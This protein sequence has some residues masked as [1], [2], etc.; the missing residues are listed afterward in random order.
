MPMSNGYNIN[1]IGGPAA[2]D[3]AFL[4]EAKEEAKTPR[5]A[6]KKKARFIVAC[7]VLAVIIGFFLLMY[8]LSRR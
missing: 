6:W 8:V 7:V 4:A 1:D 2:R 5:A 3:A